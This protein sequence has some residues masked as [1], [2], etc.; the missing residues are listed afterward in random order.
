MLFVFYFIFC[1]LARALKGALLEDRIVG[2]ADSGSSPFR[3][4]FT[5]SA[6]H[7]SQTEIAAQR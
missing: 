4:D 3:S 1:D 7:E 6:Q 2:L 5:L